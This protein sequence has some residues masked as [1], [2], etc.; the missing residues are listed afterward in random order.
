MNMD[1]N[2]LNKIPVNNIQKYI[3]IILHHGQVEFFPGI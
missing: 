3:K 1:I 2:I